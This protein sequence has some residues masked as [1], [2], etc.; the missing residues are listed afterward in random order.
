MKL[1]YEVD[2]LLRYNSFWYL[3]AKNVKNKK[4]NQDKSEK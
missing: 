3:E 2:Y 1:V 4:L